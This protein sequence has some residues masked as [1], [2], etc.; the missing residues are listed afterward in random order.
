[1]LSNPD[2]TRYCLQTVQE[3]IERR[4]FRE[5]YPPLSDI[6]GSDWGSQVYGWRDPQHYLDYA[7]SLAPLYYAE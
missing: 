7:L 5:D 6:L 2:G 3:E 4:C 1:M